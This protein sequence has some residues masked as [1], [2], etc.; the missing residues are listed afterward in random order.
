MLVIVLNCSS[1]DQ[2]VNVY[3]K[4]ALGNPLGAYQTDNIPSADTTISYYAFEPPESVH[5]AS[6]VLAGGNDG[7]ESPWGTRPPGGGTS[8]IYWAVDIDP[9]QQNAVIVLMD[10]GNNIVTQMEHVPDAGIFGT[11]H[12][13]M[14]IKK[15]K[16]DKSK[17]PHK[18]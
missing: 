11:H 8:A 9:H 15:P 6:V 5:G 7:P 1:Y 13:G 17:K 4:D 18:K 10:T 12:L 3:V 16:L 2:K 14:V